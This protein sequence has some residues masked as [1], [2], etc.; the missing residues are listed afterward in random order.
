MRAG[1]VV[2]LLLTVGCTSL[3]RNPVPIEAMDRAVIPGMPDVR[4]WGDE[5][6]RRFQDDLM[7]SVRDDWR[8]QLD[9]SGSEPPAAAVLLLSGGGSNGAFGA[10][11]LTGWTE[12]GTRPSF[13]LVTGIS[14]GALIAPFAFLGPAY[15]KQLE[16]MFTTITSKDIYKIRSPFK[17]L[18]SESLAVTKPLADLVELAVDQTLLES[19]AAAHE[20]GRRLYIGTTNLDAQRLV[21]WNMGAIAAGGRPGSIELFRKVLLASASIPV[22]FPPVYFEVEV[23]GAAYD[24]MHVDGGVIAEFF[25]W[26]AMIDI[27]DAMQDLGIDPEQRARGSIYV[28]RNGQVDAAP[29]QVSRKLIDIAGRSMTT[30]IKSVA[31]SDLIRIW[32]LAERDGIDFNYVGIPGDSK[33]LDIDAFSPEEMRRLFDRGHAMALEDEPWRQDLPVFIGATSFNSDVPRD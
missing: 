28:I 30:L 9:R 27:A 22:A 19:I 25:L 7:Q 2:L 4:D 15:D 14:T 6:S 11:F 8:T 10:G 16:A 21:V 33:E 31:M 20:A 26:G 13:K 1:A 12:A 23:D 18:R 32:A 5:P 24:E 29:E 3:T 17:V